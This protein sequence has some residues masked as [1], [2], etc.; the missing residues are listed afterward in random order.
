MGFDGTVHESIKFDTPKMDQ[1]TP[2]TYLVGGFN[3]FEKH[4][5]DWII[6]AGIRG[7]NK[8]YLENTI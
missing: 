4:E 8:K 3:P 6:S 1:W 7:E 5:S 2:G